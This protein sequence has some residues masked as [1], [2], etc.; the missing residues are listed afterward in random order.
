MRGAWHGIRKRGHFERMAWRKAGGAWPDGASIA[1]QPG[2]IVQ[3][4]INCA[5]VGVMSIYPA[6]F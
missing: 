5:R 1:H 4:V 2:V 3:G 6:L